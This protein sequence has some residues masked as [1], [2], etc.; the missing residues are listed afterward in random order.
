MALADGNVPPGEEA[1]KGEWPT[2][3]GRCHPDVVQVVDLAVLLEKQKRPDLTRADFVV[4]A[5]EAAARKVI[6]QRG[7]ENLLKKTG[8]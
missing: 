8:S 2:I 4:E 6:K 1:R 5:S 3:G 7:A